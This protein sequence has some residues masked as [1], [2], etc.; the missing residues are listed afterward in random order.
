MPPR[1]ASDLNDLE[2]GAAEKAGGRDEDEA[3]RPGRHLRWAGLTKTVEAREAQAGLLR[4]SIAGGGSKAGDGT[5][6]GSGSG[7]N[8]KSKSKS[9][10]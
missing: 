9:K 4:G 2:S 8:S 7:S 3:P 10:S 1:A 5:G 6:S